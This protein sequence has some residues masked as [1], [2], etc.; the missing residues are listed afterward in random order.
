MD[1]KAKLGYRVRLPQPPPNQ[2]SNEQRGKASDKTGRKSKLV[3]CLF[4]Q[5]VLEA[6]LLST[7]LLY[8]LFTFF[9]T[10]LNKPRL[11]LNSQSSSVH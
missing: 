1:L 9:Q 7:L 11:A 2:T 6:D 8:F 3:P 5:S 4:P 10:G